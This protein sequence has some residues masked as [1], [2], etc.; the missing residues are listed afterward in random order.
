MVAVERRGRPRAARLD[1]VGRRVE[2]QPQVIG[3]DRPKRD[4]FESVGEHATR[5]DLW[6]DHGARCDCER[7]HAESSYE[8]PSTFALVVCFDITLV[9]GHPEGCRRRLNNEE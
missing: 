3:V 9:P 4:S 2:P 7:F 6:W 5:V 8:S 1:G